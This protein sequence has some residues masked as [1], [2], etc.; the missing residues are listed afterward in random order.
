MTDAV[1]TCKF[2]EFHR[3]QDE[4][5]RRGVAAAQLSGYAYRYGDGILRFNG[6]RTVN[7]GNPIEAIPYFLGSPPA[8][9][10]EL[11]QL[12]RID[13]AARAFVKAPPGGKAGKAYK[14]LQDA[15][16]SAMANEVNPKKAL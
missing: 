2:C 10:S 14:V 6:G 12:R 16:F 4:R 8:T 1:C 15:L 9:L 3:S 13:Q 11:E 7:G 5:Q